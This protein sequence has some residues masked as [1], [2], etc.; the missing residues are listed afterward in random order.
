MKNEFS[1]FLGGLWNVDNPRRLS[2]E[3][4]AR[5]VMGGHYKVETEWLRSLPRAVYKEQ[6][7]RVDVVTPSCVCKRR[8]TSGVV[9]H[10]GLM[11]LDYDGLDEDVFRSVVEAM[12]GDEVLGTVL[13]FRS[14]GG[15]GLKQLIR[16]PIHDAL[17]GIESA[18][19]VVD[20]CERLARKH[21]RYYRAVA[22][23]VRATYGFE[24][25]RAGSD[26]ARGCTM[27]HDGEAL[28]SPE[29]GESRL[30]LERWSPEEKR[31]VAHGTIGDREAAL[32]AEVCRRVELSGLGLS[33]TYEDWVRLGLSLA[34]LGEAGRGIYHR[35]S[36]LS[37]KYRMEETDRQFS[38]ALRH[39]NGRVG[40]GTFYEMASRD[41]L[42]DISDCCRSIIIRR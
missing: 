27:C 33:D 15:H 30:D 41:A 7:K 8:S 25:D 19:E 35:L 2:L 11:V 6:R 28:Y 20:W 40:L 34:C 13:M 26:L 16:V 29:R 21:K 3:D 18:G 4:M 12:M 1:I 38:Y 23:Y 39:R 24:L 42:V 9:A 17:I 36:A 10:S 32:A 31:G 5:G 22:E 14:P 37:A